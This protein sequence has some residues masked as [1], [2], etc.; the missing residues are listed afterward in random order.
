MS[1]GARGKAPHLA[2]LLIVR[3]L[4]YSNPCCEAPQTGPEQSSR[5]LEFVDY[6]TS[7]A[8]ELFN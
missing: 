3:A 2:S 8:P 4:S 5:V 7:P 1:D 6:G